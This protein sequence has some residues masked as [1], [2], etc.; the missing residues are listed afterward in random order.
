[1][2]SRCQVISSRLKGGLGFEKQDIDG[3]CV[4]ERKKD[5]DGRM[6]GRER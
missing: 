2:S 6:C 5:V 4:N 1:M 3:K